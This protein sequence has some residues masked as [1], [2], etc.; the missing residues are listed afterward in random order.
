MPAYRIVEKPIRSMTGLGDRPLQFSPLP[1]LERACMVEFT[2]DG[3]RWVEG[4]YVGAVADLPL[5][6]AWV[7]AV[8]GQHVVAYVH[9]ETQ[10]LAF[11]R[12]QQLVA[13]PH[14]DWGYLEARAWHWLTEPCA[15]DSYYIELFHD[16]CASKYGWSVSI[17]CPPWPGIVLPTTRTVDTD[18]DTDMPRRRLVFRGNHT[19]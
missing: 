15:R 3:S 1:P 17:H 11:G 7:C 13:K 4:R 5:Q 10:R 6:E 8:G 12:L 18:T 14:D 19:D 9:D 16:Y 2:M